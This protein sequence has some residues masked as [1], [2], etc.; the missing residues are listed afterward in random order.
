MQMTEITDSALLAEIE[1]RFKEK[2]ASVEEM[3]LMTKELLELNEKNKNSQEVKSKFLS[4]IKNEFNNP[5]SSLLNLANLMSKKAE[6][7]QMNDLSL[8]MKTELLHLDFSLKNIFSASEIEAGEIANDYS[9]IDFKEILNEVKEYFSSLIEEK[10]LEIEFIDTLNEILI[11]DSQ[12]IEIILLNLIS[13]ACEY[14]YPKSKISIQLQSNDK[15]YII[16][17]KD[18]GEGVY[19]QYSENIYNRF[20]HFETGK[21]RATAGLG[22]GL[23]VVRGMVQALDGTIENRFED[24]KTIFTFTIKKVDENRVDIATG[25]ASNGFLFDDSDGMVEF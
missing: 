15:E 17:V 4:L 24:G 21:T 20:T 23:S 13:N 6:N 5:M 18:S 3:E 14:S 10:E 2:T 22:L 25:I 19:E 9:N 11:S 1:R 16:C 7:P 8:L 12:K